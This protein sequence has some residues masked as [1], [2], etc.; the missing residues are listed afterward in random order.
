M[1]KFV[2]PLNS[3]QIQQV[4]REAYAL[5]FLLM[6]LGFSPDDL[7]A[8]TANVANAK[9]PGVYA[10]VTLKAQGKEFLYWIARVCPADER[11]FQRAWVEFAKKQPELS[12]DLLDRIVITSQVYAQAPEIVTKVLEK[13]FSV[14]EE[15]SRKWLGRDEGHE[16]P[17]SVSPELAMAF[18]PPVPDGAERN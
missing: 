13:G 1:P 7:W 9:P 14:P 12:H 6:N 8:G 16:P 5:H 11:R 2:R 10:V 18:A 15:L 3:N 17:A 4:V